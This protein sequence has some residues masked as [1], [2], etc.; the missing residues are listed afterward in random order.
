L[1]F[2]SVGVKKKPLP[3][4]ANAEDQPASASPSLN[5]TQIFFSAALRSGNA[6][7]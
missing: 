2:G 6:L 7:T 1:D 3:A 5:V 4:P